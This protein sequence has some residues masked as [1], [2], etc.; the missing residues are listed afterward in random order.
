MNGYQIGQ[1]IGTALKVAFYCAG[2][3]AF[4][5]YLVS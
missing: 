2:M 5:K 1:W 3:L 4:V